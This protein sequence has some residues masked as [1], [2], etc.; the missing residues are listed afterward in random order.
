MAS[1]KGTKA[2]ENLLKAFACE[3]QARSRYTLFEVSEQNDS[4]IEDPMM[5]QLDLPTAAELTDLAMQRTDLVVSLCLPT[6]S[7]SLETNAD[8]ILL[9]NL[10]K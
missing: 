7:V 6:R 8:R 10:A 5:L 2:E 4:S 1:L 3:S 9:K